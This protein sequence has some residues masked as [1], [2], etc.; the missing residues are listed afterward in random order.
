[1]ADFPCPAVSCKDLLILLARLLTTI[2]SPPEPGGVKT[3]VAD[4]LF[5]KQQLLINLS[6]QGHTVRLIAAT[7]FR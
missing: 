4:S 3:L 6:R 5:M 7:P 1:M 2:A